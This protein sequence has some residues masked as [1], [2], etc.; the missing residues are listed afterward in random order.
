MKIKTIAG[1]AEEELVDDESTEMMDE[2]DDYGVEIDYDSDGESLDNV[3]EGI[4]ANVNASKLLLGFRK[5]RRWGG[6]Q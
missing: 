5:P 6:F 1:A 4:I 2:E 3:G